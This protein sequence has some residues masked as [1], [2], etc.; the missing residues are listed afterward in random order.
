T[1]PALA[2][3]RDPAEPDVM[4]RPPRD[5]AEALVTWNFGLRI[6]IEGALLAAGVLSAYLWAAWQDGPGPRASTM[7]FVAIV[8]IHP[9]QAM[10]CRSPR[11]PWWRLPVNPLSWVSLIVLVALQWAAVGYLPMNRLLSTEPLALSDWA[12]VS[13]AV[14]WPVA[15]VEA[16]KAWGWLVP[17]GHAR[18]KRNGPEPGGRDETLRNP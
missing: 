12:V 10:H 5:P 14:L 7:A 1:L 13:A 11:T 6:L 9:F 2:L 17:L 18:P 15:L 8:L 4:T 16:A 3:V